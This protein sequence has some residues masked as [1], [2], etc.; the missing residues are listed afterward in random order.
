M[1]LSAVGAR[2]AS[3]QQNC[4]APDAPLIGVLSEARQVHPNGTPIRA[5][6]IDLGR[7]ACVAGAA[8]DGGQLNVQ[9][10]HVVPADGV[11]D[12]RLRAAMGQ[13]VTVRGRELM[14]AHTAWHLGDAVL[15][16]ATLVDR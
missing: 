6:Q 7:M 12:Q 11:A 10:V 8:L 2:D 9:R 4:I 13:R 15:L 16:D 14:E 5:F 3:A 1:V